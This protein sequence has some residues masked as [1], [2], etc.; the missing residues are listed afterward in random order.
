MTCCGS[1][2]YS[3]KSRPEPRYPNHQACCILPAPQGC[4]SQG[5]SPVPFQKCLHASPGQLCPVHSRSSVVCW[6]S[7]VYSHHIAPLNS[8]RVRLQFCAVLH[9]SSAPPPTRTAAFGARKAH[10]PSLVLPLLFLAWPSLES[11][12]QGLNLA[13]GLI[14]SPHTCR[15]GFYL[16]HPREEAAPM[17]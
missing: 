12:G 2:S 15:A 17:V 4:C 6:P 7:P 13:P 10:I 14:S 11:A 1:Q 8:W 5:T 16:Q 3:E 9:S